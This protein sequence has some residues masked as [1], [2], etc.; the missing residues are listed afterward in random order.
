VP[1]RVAYEQLVQRNI[2]PDA[3]LKAADACIHRQLHY[4]LGVVLGHTESQKVLDAIEELVTTAVQPAIQIVKSMYAFTEWIAQEPL[5][6]DTYMGTPFEPIARQLIADRETLRGQASTVESTQTLAELALKVQSLLDSG[7]SD[8]LSVATIRDRTNALRYGSE[9]KAAAFVRGTSNILDALHRATLIDSDQYAK[10]CASVE[11]L[12][13]S[14][15][16]YRHLIEA[17]DALNIDIR[18]HANAHLRNLQI[19]SGQDPSLILEIIHSIYEGERLSLRTALDMD[20]A[21]GGLLILW[22]VQQG[23]IEGQLTLAGG[24]S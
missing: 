4:S 15:K 5:A 12:S 6:L 19:P 13:S 2:W 3:A 11:V 18:T 10:F 14:T 9:E 20:H 1:Y 23:V 24:S 17:I 8:M 22:L 7:T 16:S 21:T